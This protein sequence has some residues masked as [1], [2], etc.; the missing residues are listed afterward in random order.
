MAI[1]AMI[2]ANMAAH[3]Y[4]E[5][6]P[7]LFRL[8]GSFAAPT[9]VFLSGLMIPFNAQKKQYNFFYFLLRGVATIVVGAT[10]DYFCWD[11]IPLCTFDV[12]YVIGLSLPIVFL[13]QKLNKYLHL[14][15]ALSFFVATPFLQFYFGYSENT[16]GIELHPSEPASLSIAQQ[17][18]VYPQ[19]T[20][21][22]RDGWF[23]IFPWMGVALLGGFIGRIRMTKTPTDGA[24][25]FIR[26]GAL[27][28]ISG[29]I[30]WC[31]QNP[32]L[33]VREG[34]SELFYP[35]TIG[36]FCTYIGSILIWMGVLQKTQKYFAL[37]F[38]AV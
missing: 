19:L 4:A 25:L 27:L 11:T 5:P 24:K 14:I 31:I 3:S 37:Q 8:F 22:L 30:I 29:I 28:V 20:H 10:L 15:L 2:A 32:N 23:P 36:Y 21:F 38:F 26:I 12:L 16:F 33:L 9:F 34:Y 6:H 18:A 13:V 17:F 7:F 1:F 35:P